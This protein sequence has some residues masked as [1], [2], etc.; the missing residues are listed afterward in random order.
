MGSANRVPI[1]NSGYC[2]SVVRRVV[3]VSGL[4]G[5]AI[6][7]LRSHNLM[8]P[9]DRLEL[10]LASRCNLFL[11]LRCKAGGMASVVDLAA[12]HY[13]PD[14]AGHFVGHRHASDT[15]RLSRKKRQKLGICCLG[16]IPGPADQRGRADHQEL[17]QIPVTHLGD[18]A[19][20]VLAST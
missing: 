5:F 12:S 6:T 15:R 17:S 20:P 7:S 18:A 10:D 19:E 1:W 3:P 11:V 4:T 9:V 13:R 8:E 16:L 2:A 14:Y